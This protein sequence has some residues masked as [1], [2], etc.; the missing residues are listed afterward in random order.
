MTYLF[1]PL[2][3]GDS[4]K[5][6]AERQHGQV[7]L[8]M[9]GGRLGQ[10]TGGLCSKSDRLTSLSPLYDPQSAPCGAV[11]AT[12][13][14]YRAYACVYES[15]CMCD[16]TLVQHPWLVLFV[17]EQEC[18]CVKSTCTRTYVHNLCRAVRLRW[19]GPSHKLTDL[20]ALRP[21]PRR[22]L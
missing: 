20:S 19:T 7:L 6:G 9:P 3:E 22:Q 5:E 21:L 1:I 11:W 4:E 10:A 18:T 12:V 16:W 14:V 2:P 13:K 15:V 17:T 8:H